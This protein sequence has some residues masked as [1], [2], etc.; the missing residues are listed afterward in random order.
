VAITIGIGITFFEVI[1][2]IGILD[3]YKVIVDIPI[4]I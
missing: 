4:S 1:D 3:S 2:K